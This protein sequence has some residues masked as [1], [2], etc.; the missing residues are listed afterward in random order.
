MLTWQTFQRGIHEVDGVGLQP[1]AVL[2]H[3]LKEK[4][5]DSCCVFEASN[6]NATVDVPR[7]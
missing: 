3:T 1:N 5:Y 4:C 2:I 7:Q 6:T